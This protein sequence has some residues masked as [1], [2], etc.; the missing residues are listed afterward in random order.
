MKTA[1]PKQEE[2]MPAF[3]RERASPNG[4]KRVFPRGPS[5]E[6]NGAAQAVWIAGLLG[7]LGCAQSVGAQQPTST[8]QTPE[9]INRRVEQLEQ[10]VR[11]LRKTQQPGGAKA[12]SAQGQETKERL[13]E[14]EKKIEE[15]TTKLDELKPGS[16]KFM[17]SGF[18]WSGFTEPAHGTSSF[19]AAFKPVFL[20]KVADNLLVAASAEFEI[21]DNATEVNIEYANINWMASDSL[22]LRGGVLL[23]PLS[24]FQQ[25]L[26]PQWINKLPDNPLF[27]GDTG[28][29]PEKC[30]GVEARGGVRSGGSRFTYSVFLTN[31]PTMNNDAPVNPG[32]PDTRGQLNLTEFTDANNN[33]AVGGRIGFQPTPEL[34]FAYAGQFSDVQPVGSTPK[35]LDLMLHDFSASYV[36]EPEALQ[37]RI[38][39]RVEM[40]LADFSKNV[41]FGTGAFNNNRSGGYAQLAYR[42]TKANSCIKDLEGVVRYD[43]LD[44]P[45]GA[46]QPA[47]E[48]RWT[49]GV[50]YWAAPRTVVKVAFEFDTVSDPSGQ[51]RANN[52]LLVQAAMGF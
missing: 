11:D 37:G 24:T 6:V 18:L 5:A 20:W 21:A 42:P 28:L 12:P 29:A 2:T 9:E 46:P 51:G 39:A 36:A 4:Q 48:H 38:D 14:Q 45:S 47:D 17:L 10:E 27:A 22:M 26:H 19:D 33:K 41:D 7:A 40:M 43:Y 13:D 23:S 16:E 3:R 8:P 30:L 49:V 34:E 1:I 32:D 44:Q 35:S 52:T 50:N 31:G 25:N 15:L